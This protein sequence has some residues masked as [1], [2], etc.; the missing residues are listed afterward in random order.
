MNANIVQK[1]DTVVRASASTRTTARP[2]ASSALTADGWACPPPSQAVPPLSRCCN[3]WDTGPGARS[4]PCTRCAFHTDWHL[5]PSA[6]SEEVPEGGRARGAARHLPTAGEHAALPRLRDSEARRDELHRA[7]PQQLRRLPVCPPPPPPPPAPIR[8]LPPRAGHAA[9][10]APRSQA[11]QAGKYRVDCAD[12]LLATPLPRPHGPKCSTAGAMSPTRRTLRSS[13]SWCAPTSERA[14][15][16]SSLVA[17]C[18]SASPTKIWPVLVIRGRR[19][20]GGRGV[21]AC[22]PQLRDRLTMDTGRQPIAGAGQ[23]AVDG[24]EPLP[25]HGTLRPLP[26]L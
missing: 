12:L 4:L 8:P 10:P 9:A 3:E 26:Q 20:G 6:G 13:T 18:A 25:L 24:G 22:Q 2:L 7:A 14:T 19:E 17:C 5:L 11:R 21:C 16:R 1:N 15:S 23:D